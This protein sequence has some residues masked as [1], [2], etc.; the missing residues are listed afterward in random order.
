MALVSA[1][2]TIIPDE[3]QIELSV[4]EA[5]ARLARNNG[6]L[7]SDVAV[8][9]TVE[10][11]VEALGAHS[12]RISCLKLE[13]AHFKDGRHY[14]NAVALRQRYGFTGDLRA[15]GDVLPDQALY[16]ARSGFSSIQVPDGF[17]AEDFLYTLKAY[18]VAYQAAVTGR[19]EEI[20]RIRASAPS[21]AAE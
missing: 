10:D 13:F 2:G 9:V 17:A 21:L 16:L 20:Q 3:I 12:A 4:A 18:S 11:D 19:L 8:R 15:T 6:P 7:G 14:T 5:L 1:D